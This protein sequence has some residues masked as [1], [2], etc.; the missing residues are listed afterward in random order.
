MQ[1]KT[2]YQSAAI[3]LERFA[4]H[5]CYELNREILAEL[6]L[7]DQQKDS[8]E[9]PSAQEV[10]NRFARSVWA[11]KANKVYLEDT[12]RFEIIRGKIMRETSK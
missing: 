6:V 12:E 1:L 4:V 9:T 5:S 8:E 11:E 7:E 2:Y 3:K 10:A